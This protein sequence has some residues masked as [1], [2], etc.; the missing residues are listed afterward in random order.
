[1]ESSSKFNYKTPKS[2]LIRKY[3]EEH[4]K[5]SQDEK[6]AMSLAKLRQKAVENIPT[7]EFESSSAF[8]NA[9]SEY[10]NLIIAIRTERSR[11][12]MTAT[13]SAGFNKKWIILIVAIIIVLLAVI[14]PLVVSFYSKKEKIIR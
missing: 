7:D 2:N 14:I 12:G 1:M 3:D 13:L 6:Y 8:D 11:G 5:Y 9:F 4:K 10:E